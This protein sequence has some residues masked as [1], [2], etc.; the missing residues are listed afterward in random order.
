[1]T[2]SH[3]RQLGNYHLIRRLGTGGFADVYLGEHMY[4]KTR[5]AL[6]VLRTPIQSQEMQQFLAEAR[7]ISSLHHSHIIRVFDFEV[8]YGTPFLVMDYAPNGTLRLVCPRGYR[9]HFPDILSY[10]KQTAAALQYAHAHGV[11][12]RDVKPENMLLGRNKGI[13]L[14]DFGIAVSV[15]RTVSLKTL[16]TVGT[17]HYMAPE[18]I[19]GKPRFASD[20]YALGVVVYEWLCGRRPFQGD[21]MQVLYQQTNSSPPP[22]HTIVPT[23]SPEIERVVLQALDKY[24][25]RRFA[26][27]EAFAMAL[28][29]AGQRHTRQTVHRRT[30]RGHAFPVTALAWSP[31]GKSILSADYGECFHI[32]D[33]ITGTTLSVDTYRGLAEAASVLAWSPDGKQVALGNRN[34]AACIR[35]IATGEKRSFSE[36]RSTVDAIMWSPNGSRLASGSVGK[37]YEDEIA[38]IV[39]VW[40]TATNKNVFTKYLFLPHIRGRDWSSLTKGGFVA[41]KW[42]PDNIRITFV[43]LDK[44]V[45]TWDTITGK[46][47]F[48]Q[49][50]SPQSNQVRSVVLSPD[51]KYLASLMKD[52]TVEVSEILSGRIICTYLG[53]QHVVNV[54]A[55]SP[56]SRFIASGGVDASV[57]VWDARTGKHISMHHGHAS[58]VRLLAW[59]PDGHSIVSTSGD[60]T[61]EVWEVKGV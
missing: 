56:H 17:P 28:E 60:N 26:S 14:S 23:I 3:H 5:V 50:A 38:Y 13:L 25:Q 21:M 30:Y 32:W 57:Q 1:M 4:L 49:M 31:D 9:L 16:D 37:V 2:K 20:Q 45:E 15:H 47:L 24:P 33:P 39:Q 12:H 42:L 55:W 34:V 58:H 41:M 8:D 59:S 27:V 44:T 43:N 54:I 6:K 7:T 18:H 29:Q 35:T 19:L 10:V 53:H 51:G 46:Q 22:L 52:Q 48:I 40:D 61:V 11:I 36:M